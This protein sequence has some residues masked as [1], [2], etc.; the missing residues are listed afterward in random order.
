M[1]RFMLLPPEVV[2]VDDDDG[3]G[4]GGGR[5]GFSSPGIITTLF[6]RVGN[7]EARA[8]WVCTVLC[9]FSEFSL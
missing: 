1:L 3:G 5:G 4:G 6:S 2:V 9:G 7:D 8:G